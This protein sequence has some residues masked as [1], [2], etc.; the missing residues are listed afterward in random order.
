MINAST[1]DDEHQMESIKYKN[2][3]KTKLKDFSLNAEGV[4]KIFE[5]LLDSLLQKKALSYEGL[6]R[7]NGAALQ[8]TKLEKKLNKKGHDTGEINFPPD[9]IATVIKRWLST[10]SSLVPAYDEIIS[11]VKNKKCK[12]IPIIILK[13]S[14]REELATLRS[15]LK[16]LRV[17][18]FIF[19]FS[20]FIFILVFHLHQ[21]PNQNKCL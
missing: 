3:Y 18:N 7:Q 14:T 10:L 15:L 11:C 12:E 20:N 13:K 17:N 1:S 21:K 16:F 6:F 8:V 5:M 2:L 4:P 9:I 19:F